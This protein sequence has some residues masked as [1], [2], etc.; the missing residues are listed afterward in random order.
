[1]KPTIYFAGK[2]GKNDWR[3]SLVDL[4][5]ID[6]IASDRDEY[7]SNSSLFDPRF[8]RENPQVLIQRTLHRLV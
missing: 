3:H 8:V 5:L 1:M 6:I 7:A 2:I 4:S